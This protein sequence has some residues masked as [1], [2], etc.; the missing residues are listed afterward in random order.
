[1]GSTRLMRRE[2]AANDLLIW[3]LGVGSRALDVDFVGSGATLLE[4]FV[5]VH[6]VEGIEPGAFRVRGD[7]I[8]RGS[9]AQRRDFAAHLCLDQPLGGDSAFTVFHACDIQPV[10]AALGSRGYR[11]PLIEAGIASGR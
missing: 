8:E 9:K 3:G 1:R 11:A 4:H 10:L 5:S 2:A 7:R 6:D